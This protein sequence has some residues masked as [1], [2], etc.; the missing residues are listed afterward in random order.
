MKPE[1]EPLCL[2][3]DATGKCDSDRVLLSDVRTVFQKAESD[4]DLVFV[5]TV[6]GQSPQADHLHPR[7]EGRGSL[8]KE[9]GRP[10]WQ[11]A[12]FIKLN[13]CARLFLGDNKTKMEAHAAWQVPKN[14]TEPRVGTVTDSS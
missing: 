12:E 3:I 6:P 10:A 1:C 8:T 9:A 13:L 7:E 2:T 14:Y 5:H 4:P 11:L